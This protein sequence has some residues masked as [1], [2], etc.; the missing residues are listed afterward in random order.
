VGQFHGGPGA[1]PIAAFRG[2]FWL[3]RNIVFSREAPDGLYIL[4]PGYAF[5][6]RFHKATKMKIRRG[7][8]CLS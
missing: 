2:I 8:Q 3:Q 7:E 4:D 1:A 5:G 6:A